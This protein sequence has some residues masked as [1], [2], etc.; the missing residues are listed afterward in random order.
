VENDVHVL[1][2]FSEALSHLGMNSCNLAVRVYA[3]D[4]PL[5]AALKLLTGLIRTMRIH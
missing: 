3:T 4:L 1:Q 5:G 2:E